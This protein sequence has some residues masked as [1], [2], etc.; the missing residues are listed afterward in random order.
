MLP[1][2][3]SIR[4]IKSLSIYRKAKKLAEISDLSITYYNTKIIENKKYLICMGNTYNYYNANVEKYADCDDLYI[5]VI[6]KK[7]DTLTL[8]PNNKWTKS[9]NFAFSYYGKVSYFSS[10]VFEYFNVNIN[11][12]DDAQRCIKHFYESRKAEIR[13]N[14]KAKDIKEKMKMWCN[15]KE[16]VPRKFK[17]FCNNDLGYKLIFSTK[18]RTTGICTNCNTRSSY[19]KIV[20]GHK[21]KCP[22]CKKEIEAISCL[23]VSNKETHKCYSMLDVFI[24]Q[25]GEKQL[26]VRHFDLSECISAFDYNGYLTDIKVDRSL[27]EYERDIF[28]T[29]FHEFSYYIATRDYYTNLLYWKNSKPSIGW[30]VWL[31]RLPDRYYFADKFYL[32][33]VDT[34]KESFPRASERLSILQYIESSTISSSIRVE[35]I[36]INM[37]YSMLAEKLLKVGLYELATDLLK[38][39]V[40]WYYNRTTIIENMSIKDYI[41]LNKTYIKFAIEENVD[42]N[43]V[44]AMR[45]FDKSFKNKINDFKLIYKYCID[46]NYSI[47]HFTD[48]II[49]FCNNYKTTINQVIKY[50]RQFKTCEMPTLNDYISMYIKAYK[51][52]NPD[53]KIVKYNKSFLFPQ[54]L[55][56]AHDAA[57]KWLKENEDKI[58]KQQLLKNEK[59]LL[60]FTKTLGEFDGLK[61]GDYKITLPHNKNDFIAQG[62]EMHICVGRLNYFEKMAEGKTIVCFVAKGND[63]YA[64]IEFRVANGKV[65][66]I[67]ARGYDNKD[68]EDR[69]AKE[70]NKMKNVLEKNIQKQ[71]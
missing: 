31:P 59:K 49:E 56:K 3:K 46:Y 5:T 53:A 6:N 44:S 29:D 58:K 22:K 41:G 20:M 8:L 35:E 11:E 15:Y 36:L 4:K 30:H 19:K 39:S 42:Y 45:T 60:S 34:I 52:S 70:L 71:R 9:L 40:G 54:D 63:R 33:N 25:D 48:D 64:T 57:E 1:S 66:L 68:L 28:S 23:K 55:K 14:K 13:N 43:T 7:G 2:K 24:N 10:S 67:Q 12:Y 65:S 47:I 50:L 17:N 32:G 69:L 61:I 26:M 37:K 18:D 27:Y 16:T 62:E 38:S 51:L 21:Y